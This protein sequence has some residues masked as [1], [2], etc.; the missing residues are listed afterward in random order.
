MFIVAKHTITDPERVRA[1]TSAA[2][3]PAGLTLH[4]A[5]PNVAGTEQICLWEAESVDAVRD[6][7]DPAL[8]GVSSNTYFAV[9][10]SAAMGLPVAA[11]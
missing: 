9:E 7:V 3:L 5:F 11:G 8:A 4:Q 6:F 1:I 10:E 2:V